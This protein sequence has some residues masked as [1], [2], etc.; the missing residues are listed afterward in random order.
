MEQVVRSQKEDRLV[1]VY[2]LSCSK[3]KILI[4][5]AVIL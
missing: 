2:K 1:H 4:I 3:L 5:N